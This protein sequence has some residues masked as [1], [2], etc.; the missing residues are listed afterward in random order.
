MIS[1]PNVVQMVVGPVLPS[2][3]EYR[4][5]ANTEGGGKLAVA[6]LPSDTQV[7]Y[8][9]GTGLPDRRGETI[10]VKVSPSEKTV[11]D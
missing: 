11:R 8:S 7:K 1:A 6:V 10:M 9:E 2:S 5:D 4:Y 3:D